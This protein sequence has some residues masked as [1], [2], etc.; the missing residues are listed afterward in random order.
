MSEPQFEQV[1]CGH[2]GTV[3]S[4]SARSFSRCPNEDCLSNV[5]GL[6]KR[7]RLRQRQMDEIAKLRKGR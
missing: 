5:S 7:R 6:E 4:C 3:F 1:Q 2:C